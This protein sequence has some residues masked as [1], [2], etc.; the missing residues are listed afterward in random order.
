MVSVL[1]RFFR[2]ATPPRPAGKALR[3]WPVFMGKTA[4]YA[5]EWGVGVDRKSVV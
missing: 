3:D 2:S 4:R 1:P 5:L